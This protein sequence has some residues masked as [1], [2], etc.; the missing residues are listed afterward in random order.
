MR[1]DLE[2]PVPELEVVAVNLNGK[3]YKYKTILVL[4]P[5]PELS[6]VPLAHPCLEDYVS[7]FLTMVL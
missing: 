4:I 2:T 1:Q 7:V 3:F 6:V 5:R